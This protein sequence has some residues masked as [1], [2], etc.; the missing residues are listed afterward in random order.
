MSKQTGRKA[1]IILSDGVTVAAK[2]PS[3]SPSKPPSA[4]TPSSTPSTSKAKSRTR[5]TR[6]TAAAV[7]ATPAAAI[8]VAAV[9]T[10][11][12]V[13]AAIPVAAAT[14]AVETAVAA[15]A[16]TIRRQSHVDGK[17]SSSAWPRRPA[18]ASSRS[19]RSQNVAQIYNQIAEEL[20]AQY[21]LGYTPSQDAA[22][23]RIPPDRSQPPP[24]GPRHPDPRRL[25]H[26]KV[27][28]N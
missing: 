21:R 24:E 10:R 6:N 28:L 8:P 17:K 1:I 11:E 14:R 7:V 27:A 18:A 9:A 12:V 5:T 26:R 4:P 13:A 25:L 2:R 22:A 19:R 16:A 3:S 15:T 23:R 20:R